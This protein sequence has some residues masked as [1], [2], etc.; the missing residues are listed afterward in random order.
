M[1]FCLARRKLRPLEWIQK[2]WMHFY[3][4]LVKEIMKWAEIFTSGFYYISL[5]Y[6]KVWKHLQTLYQQCVMAL[7]MEAFTDTLPIVCNGFKQTILLSNIICMSQEPVINPEIPL[8]CVHTHTH[9]GNS[10]S[11]KTYPFQTRFVQEYIFLNYIFCP[12]N[13]YEFCTEKQGIWILGL[14][15]LNIKDFFYINNK[16]F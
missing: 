12:F 1:S 3:C 15:F 6:C 13:Q 14:T 4:F 16:I 7:C 5:D 10:M 11:A 9:T 2:C 8:W